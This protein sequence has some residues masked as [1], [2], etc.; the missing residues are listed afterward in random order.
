[1]KNLKQQLNKIVGEWNGREAGF[2]EERAETAI[3]ALEKI[4]EL[5]ELLKELD[6]KDSVEEMPQF[7]G[8]L[9][10]LNNLKIR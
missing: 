1:M 8:T 9:D 5:E 6:I 2:Q 3:D 7:K 10:E 4:E